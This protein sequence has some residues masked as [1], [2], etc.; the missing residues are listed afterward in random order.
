MPTS[1]KH[2]GFKKFWNKLRFKYRLIIL[3]EETYEQ[4]A[5]LRLSQMNM[6]ILFSVLLIIFTAIITAIIA[7]TPLKFYMPGVGSVDVRSQLMAYELITDSLE[8]EIDSRNFW[9]QNVQNVLSGSVDSMKILND[10]VPV[11]KDIN[12]DLGKESKTEI[13]FKEDVKEEVT[14]Q[15]VSMKSG[16]VSGASYSLLKFAAPADGVVISNYKTEENHYGIDIAGNEKS[17]VY[18]V[19]SGY[20]LVSD[21]SPE[22]GNV[23]VIAHRDNMASF[24]KHN[25]ELL[26]KSGNFVN[27]GDVIALMGNTGTL[28]NGPHLHFEL[29]R[30]GRPVDPLKFINITKME[31]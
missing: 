8:N 24:Y 9:L 26:K 19:E 1:K 27:K 6:Y 25:A 11:H 4:K 22:F 15:A 5:S 23:I 17:P 16:I 18:A 30:D 10:S 20:V 31:E 21:W 2:T 12:V 7:F 29:W 14:S 13:A 3:N 28:S